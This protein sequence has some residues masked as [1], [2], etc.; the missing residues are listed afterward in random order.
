[1]SLNSLHLF[2]NIGSFPLETNDYT[3][4]VKNESVDHEV[5]P[6][7]EAMLKRDVSVLEHGIQ[8][9]EIAIQADRRRLVEL[10]LNSS[11]D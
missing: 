6:P 10:E 7:H 4:V 5:V 8:P 1:M 2:G 3:P 9:L 11:V